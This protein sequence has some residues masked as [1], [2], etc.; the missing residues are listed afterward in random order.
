MNTSLQKGTMWLFG[1]AA[2]AGL[3]LFLMFYQSSPGSLASPHAGAIPG[4]SIR[5]CK[6]CHAEGGLDEGCLSCHVEI[7]GQLENDSGFHAYL[8]R[9]CPASCAACHPE[10]LGTDF[11]LAGDV[12]W[13]DLD[14]ENFDHAHIDFK[15]TGRHEGLACEKCHE[16]KLKE[17]FTLPGFPEHP[18]PATFLGLEQGCA[19]CHEDVHGS[20]DATRDC[21]R[22]H[23]QN[24]FKPAAFFNHDEHFVLEGLHAK[25]E[26]A[27]CHRQGETASTTV[28]GPVQG[29]SCTD[30]HESPHRAE[31]IR[32][33][34]CHACHLASDETWT[35]GERGIDPPLHAP[36]G[37]ALESPHADLECAACHP[38]E[39]DYAERFPDPVRQPDQCRACHDDPHAGQFVEKYSRCMDCHSR[40]R[41]IPS[42]IGPARHSESYPLQ[43]GHLAVACTQCHLADEET[44]VRQ[45][46]ALPVACKACHENPHGDQFNDR[47]QDGDCTVC[48]LADSNT[49]M[50]RPYEHRGAREFFLGKGHRQA[51]CRKCHVAEKEGSLVVYQTAP[52]SCASCHADVHRGQFSKNGTTKCVRCHDTTEQW[53]IRAFVHDRD[54][55]FKLDAAHAKVECAACHLPVPQPD[56][57]PVVQYKPLTK[58]CEDCH[59]FTTD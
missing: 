16:G 30:C 42:D 45:F 5:S 14:R 57:T 41:F 44:G 1:I 19:A 17:P 37:F 49:F 47:L 8:G 23:D 56:G 48:H 6:E 22:C 9:E 13:K 31:A 29:I 28:F 51:D 18:R 25:A 46:A 4:S 50:I 38:P 54:S 26:C 12:A 2:L 10:H 39:L 24:Q 33:E 3:A 15:L 53:S 20:G 32:K 55:D 7:A 27:A 36:F 58:R 52:T 43:G 34:D 11:A 40:R 21:E 59:G 35:L